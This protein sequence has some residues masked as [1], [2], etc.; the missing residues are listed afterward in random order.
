M[1]TVHVG[2]SSVEIIAIEATEQGLIHPKAS[3]NLMM[4]DRHND[5]L[6]KPSNCPKLSTISQACNVAVTDEKWL[7]DIY[8]MSIMISKHVQLIF[9]MI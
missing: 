3:C 8:N 6:W 1:S 9:S 4:P 2:A 5:L 7:D